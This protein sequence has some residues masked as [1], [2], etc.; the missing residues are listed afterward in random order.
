[1]VGMVDETPQGKWILVVEDDEYINKAYSAK[2]EHEQIPS[3]FAVE[4]DGAMKILREA[5]VLPVLILLDL[6][7][8][9]KNGFEILKDIK[10]DEKLKAIPVIILTNLAQENDA[11]RGMELGAVKYLI[12]AD[13]KIADILAEVKNYIQ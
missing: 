6:M 2:F 4:G 10:A 9:G 7:L 12:K 1:M 5:P 11:K 8:P 13:T 3:K